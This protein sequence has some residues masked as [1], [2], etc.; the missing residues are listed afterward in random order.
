MGGEDASRSILGSGS[1]EEAAASHAQDWSAYPEEEWSLASNSPKEPHSFEKR[2]G[3]YQQPSSSD[4]QQ[5]HGIPNR[6]EK[7]PTISSPPSGP[8]PRAIT[9]PNAIIQSAV[10]QRV[11]PA[12][13]NIATQQET[14]PVALFSDAAQETAS[15]SQPSGHIKTGRPSSASSWRAEAADTAQPGTPRQTDRSAR[16]ATA[17]DQPSSPGPPLAVSGR[18]LAPKPLSRLKRAEITTTPKA[19]ATAARSVNT[20]AFENHAPATLPLSATSGVVTMPVAEEIGE[21]ADIMSDQHA[22]TISNY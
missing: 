15:L 20:N 17:V 5:L 22:G 12:F 21:L 6:K 16:A 10:R 13:K 7:S 4:A 3:A 1:S 8:K 2:Q 14:E 11:P 9:Q 18:R 19:D